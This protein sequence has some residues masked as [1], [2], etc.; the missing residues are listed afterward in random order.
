[1][2]IPYSPYEE[3][4]I[5]TDPLG[6]TDMGKDML[7]QDYLLKQLTSSLISPESEIGEQFWKQVYAKTYDQ[8]GTVDIPTD[9]FNKIWI[10]PESA[11][12]HVHKQNVFISEAKLKVMLDEDYLAMEMN[13]NRTDH[14]L[15]QIE[16]E[17]LKDVGMST[18]TLREV[19]VPSIQKEVNEGTIFANLRQIYHALILATWYKE[20]LEGSFLSESY[21]DQDEIDSIALNEFNVKQKIHKRY[22][23]SFQSGIYDLIHEDYD[24]ASQSIITRKYFSGGLALNVSPK[25]NTDNAILA[26]RE[27]KKYIQVDLSMVSKVQDK[28]RVTQAKKLLTNSNRPEMDDL[29]GLTPK[30]IDAAAEELGRP[31]Y[32]AEHLFKLHEVALP[33]LSSKIEY[34]FKM[35]EHKKPHYVAMGRDGEMIYDALQVLSSYK[36]DLADR[37]HLVNIGN[38]ILEQAENDETREDLKKYLAQF[39]ITKESLQKEK[40]VFLDAGF[41]GSIFDRILELF[42]LTAQDVS[43]NLTGYLISKIED[44]NYLELPWSG[45]PPDSAFS[46]LFF[47]VGLGHTLFRY[48]TKAKLAKDFLSFFPVERANSY[49]LASWL[50]VMPKFNYSSNKVQLVKGIWNTA[51]DSML[52]SVLANN[53]F[54][55]ENLESLIHFLNSEHIDPLAA[56]KIQLKTK[57]FFSDSK[58]YSQIF[59][60]NNSVSQ[61]SDEMSQK[62]V[63]LVRQDNFP[64]IYEIE[65]MPNNFKIPHHK[66]TIRDPNDNSQYIFDFRKEYFYMVSPENKRIEFLDGV[67][68]Q[69]QI[70]EDIF[71][72][73]IFILLTYDDSNIDFSSGSKLQSIEIFEKQFFGIKIKYLGQG[74]IQRFFTANREEVFDDYFPDWYN[75]KYINAKY[76]QEHREISGMDSRAEELSQKIS[77]LTLSDGN[78]VH[79]KYIERESHEEKEITGEI[80]HFSKNKNLVILSADGLSKSLLLTFDSD[81]DKIISIDILGNPKKTVKINNKGGI[82]F[83]VRGLQIKST[84]T[85]IFPKWTLDQYPRFELKD[86]FPKIDHIFLVDPNQLKLNLGLPTQ[87][88]I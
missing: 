69:N 39:G 71:Q 74:K 54:I 77:E 10:V 28:E 12:L 48:D 88:Q 1:L 79:I 59:Q 5:I 78:K 37:L 57:E 3:N 42:E 86:L 14:G 15:G 53:N 31:V 32:K 41:K 55:P 8:L 22:V 21:S 43:T 66:I 64:S 56:V 73:L 11:S 72:K 84:E 13:Q 7:I 6:A 40:W 83:N 65:K 70:K 34:L 38:M 17:N 25:D 60:N 9:T 29:E 16:K 76:I 35:H 44:S 24:P 67:N 26:M 82:D 19:I 52:K 87:S 49:A 4:R 36:N 75:L 33:A 58:N 51:Y 80:T 18:E 2:G 85:M 62:S 47:K 61:F 81:G 46:L 30:I 63:D 45:E 23:Q 50:Q 68:T 27:D 20:N